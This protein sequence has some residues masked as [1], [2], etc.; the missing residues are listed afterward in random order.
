[1]GLPCGLGVDPPQRGVDADP[2]ARQVGHAAD[3][4]HGPRAT[5]SR[6]P[7]GADELGGHVLRRSSATKC[8]PSRAVATSGLD[9]GWIVVF[10]DRSPGASGN[11][12]AV[13]PSL[14]RHHGAHASVLRDCVP[15]QRHTRALQG[16]R[17]SRSDVAYGRSTRASREEHWSSRMTGCSPS[18]GCRSD[19]R[20]IRTAGGHL[21][22]V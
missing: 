8:E 4:L 5:V 10:S 19:A 2:A 15:Q 6:P 21:L 20:P 14:M 13:N 3:S 16:R 9:A 11:Y 18:R 7:P 12:P 17:G 1:M 22:L